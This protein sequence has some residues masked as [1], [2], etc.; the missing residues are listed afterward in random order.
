MTVED[1]ISDFKD[2]DLGPARTK[3]LLDPL[4]E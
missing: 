3:N 2:F 4:A 1:A